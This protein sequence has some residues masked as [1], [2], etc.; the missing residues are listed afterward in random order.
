MPAVTGGSTYLSYSPTV[1]QTVFVRGVEILR[2]AG[3][4][5]SA[6][7]QGIAANRLAAR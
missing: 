3:E 1:V 5:T 2:L 6:V 7:L 4:S